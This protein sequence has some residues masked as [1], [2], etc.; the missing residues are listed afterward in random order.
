VRVNL[1][2]PGP[3]RTRMRAQI[4]PGEDP[5]ALPTPEDV[6]EKVLELCLPSCTETGALYD[7]YAKKFLQFTA[8]A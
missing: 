1:F 7:F 2:N 4:M 3:T 6:A 5:M 8:P